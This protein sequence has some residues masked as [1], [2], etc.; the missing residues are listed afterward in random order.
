[1][2]R[3]TSATTLLVAALVTVLGCA[4]LAQN[5]AKTEPKTVH[6]RTLTTAYAGAAGFDS[7]FHDAAP[8]TARPAQASAQTSH[9]RGTFATLGSD[10]TS[11]KSTGVRSSIRP[12]C[13]NVSM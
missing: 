10:P 9:V 2:A 6:R 1:M 11:V 3:Q 8:A 4:L 13:V 5:A 12:L 7:N